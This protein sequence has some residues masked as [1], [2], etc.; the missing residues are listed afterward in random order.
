MTEFQIYPAI[1]L[2]DGQVVRLRQGIRNQMT[3]YHLAPAEAAQ[4]WITAGTGWLHVINLDG[5]FDSPDAKNL[6]ALKA[7]VAVAD[8][9]ARVQFGGGLR[10]MDSLNRAFAAGISRAIIGTAAVQ[11]PDLLVRA[12]VEYG[13][14]RIIVGL[15]ARDGVVKTM[16]WTKDSGERIET[17]GKK[18]YAMG[19]RTVIYTDISR[20]GMGTGVDT[21]G[22]VSLRECG[23]RVIASGGTGSIEDVLHVQSRGFSGVVVGKALYDGRLDLQSALKSVAKGG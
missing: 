5:A 16:G 2:I 13:A 17:M 11:S 9:R 8:G 19:V 7:I 20:D 15:D 23:L 1:D 14:D 21:D 22:A 4:R 10:S 12:I 6:N 3:S 18:L